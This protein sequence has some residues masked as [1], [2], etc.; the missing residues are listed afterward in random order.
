MS[1]LTYNHLYNKLKSMRN[2]LVFLAFLLVSCHDSINPIEANKP[3]ETEFV[4]PPEGVSFISAEYDGKR[5]DF[6]EN[7]N[8]VKSLG[9]TFT[10]RSSDTVAA[11]LGTAVVGLGET[12]SDSL[13]KTQWTIMLCFTRQEWL[14]NAGNSTKLL[15]SGS[16]DFLFQ[17]KSYHLTSTSPK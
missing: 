10:N 13:T 1:E 17:D 4:E 3:V 2:V 11:K 15:K 8:G 5:F 9:T 6:I 14:L 12:L 16:H 7:Q